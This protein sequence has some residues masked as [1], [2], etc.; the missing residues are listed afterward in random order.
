MPSVNGVFGSLAE[1]RPRGNET[2]DLEESL[3]MRGRRQKAIL[4]SSRIYLKGAL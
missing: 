3:K 4:D 2:T 1:D